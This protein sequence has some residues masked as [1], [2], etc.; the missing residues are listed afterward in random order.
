[1]SKK[2]EWPIGDF[3]LLSEKPK[4]IKVLF[5][6]V[7][8]TDLSEE[9]L[10]ELMDDSSHCIVEHDCEILAFKTAEVDETT[11][12]VIEEPSEDPTTH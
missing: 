10:E 1:M 4:T 9:E 6:Q 11:G 3:S 5:I 12:E 7:D 8:V 2:K